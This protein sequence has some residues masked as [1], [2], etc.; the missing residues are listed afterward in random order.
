M[1]NLN[2]LFLKY[3]TNI[4]LSNIERERII[5]GRDALRNKITSKFK[6]KGKSIP[7]FCMQGSFI[8]KTTVIPKEGEE[9]DLDNG[10]YIQGYSDDISKWPT[11]Q[12]IHNWIYDGVDGHTDTPP[13][14]K[15]TCIRVIYKADYHIDLPSYIVRDEEQ[16][17]KTII[18]VAYLAHKTKGWIVSDPRSFTNWFRE[19][20]NDNGEQ[21]RRLVKYLKGWKENKG[22]DLK[23]IAITILVGN[24][25]QGEK[26]RDDIAL[27]STI[28]NIID[29]L[30]D[31]FQCYKPVIP[32]DE[33]LFSGASETTKTSIMNGLNTL[34]KKLDKAIN[35]INNEKEAAAEL[36]KILGDSFPEGEDIIRENMAYA[37]T[38]APILLSKEN[39]HFA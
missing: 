17:D 14:D 10:I 27:L 8:M 12:T 25:F 39:H 31:N 9:Y 11:T 34:K 4:S 13:V 3:N 29:E 24:H 21:L 18:K 36:R 16:E 35:E 15:N 5:K 28:T 23:G 6:E 32:T 26:E 19:K 20:V 1:A 33:D 7:K 22:I 30:E 37:S 2:E 38:T